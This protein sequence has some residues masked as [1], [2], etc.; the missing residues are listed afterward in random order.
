M[1]GKERSACVALGGTRANCA[2]AG[3][4]C[5]Q[6]CFSSR[7]ARSVGVNVSMPAIDAAPDFSAIALGL[8]GNSGMAIA[9]M[10]CL[11]P[12]AATTLSTSPLSTTTKRSRSSAFGMRLR[13]MVSL[14]AP[15]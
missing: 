9:A 13:L 6:S 4:L 3:S 7:T 8:I 10:H 2:C 11:T 14:D 1:I 12:F 5:V 15:I